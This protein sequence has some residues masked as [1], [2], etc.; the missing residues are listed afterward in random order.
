MRLAIEDGLQ[1]KNDRTITIASNRTELLT[2]HIDALDVSNGYKFVAEGLSGLRFRNESQL[3]IQSKN[4]SI[5][6]QTDKAI[7]KPAEAI[8]FRV[9]V[10]D[11][12]LRPAALAAGE[13]LSIYVTDSEKNRIRQWVNGTLTKGVFAGEVQ[14]SEQPVLGDWTISTRIGN[15]VTDGRAFC[16]CTCAFPR[17]NCAQLPVLLPSVVSEKK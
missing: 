12:R 6:I 11:A 9:L 8:K 7:Y 13:Q 2:L 14:L 3:R 16:R 5:F 17:A 15:E 1:Y 10:L 4:V